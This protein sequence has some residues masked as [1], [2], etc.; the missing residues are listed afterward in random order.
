MNNKKHAGRIN[1]LYYKLHQGTIVIKAI[2]YYHKNGHI[3]QLTKIESQDIS[4][5]P[6]IQVIF[7]KETKKMHIGVKRA[8][9][10]NGTGSMG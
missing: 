4:P 7:D 3:D 2:W 8:S 1:I 6:Y 9:S 10:T 5:Q